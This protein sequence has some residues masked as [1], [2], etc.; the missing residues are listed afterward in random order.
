MSAKHTP[1]PWVVKATVIGPVASVK[2]IGR[3][4]SDFSDQEMVCMVPQTN[5]EQVANTRLIQSAPD[6]LQALK[7]IVSIDAH[8]AL[9]EAEADA[10]Y[11]QA[12]AAIAKAEA[13]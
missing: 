12:H 10:I 13:A 6:L 3:K 11:A 1:G 9:T 4:G 8:S 7:A 2:A 5:E